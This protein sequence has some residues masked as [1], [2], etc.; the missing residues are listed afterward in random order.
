VGAGAR[1]RVDDVDVE[2][3]EQRE[4]LALSSASALRGWA[5]NCSST[6]TMSS[7]TV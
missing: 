7:S 1:P 4:L 5:A 3:F 2:D 6:E